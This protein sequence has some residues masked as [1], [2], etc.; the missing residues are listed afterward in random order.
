MLILDATASV[1]SMWYQKENPF[2]VF[3]DM[4]A[5]TFSGKTEHMK[6]RAYKYMVYP[7]IIAKW[8]HLPFKDGVFDMVVFDPPHILIEKGKK[9]PGISNK[10][11]VFYK[12]SWRQ[13]II[14]SGEEL[15]RVL[16]PD[17]FFVLK[18][19]EEDIEASEVIKL[20]SY[21][22]LFG[23]R[24]GQKNNTHWITF[25]KYRQDSQLGEFC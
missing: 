5:G 11:G 17:G 1:R 9:P 12:H 3:M 10:Y 6:R 20:F 25:I 13:E 22:P 19:N 8:Q 14:K 21:K 15:F 4:R 2:T 16:K 18:W 7:D 24:T 23:T